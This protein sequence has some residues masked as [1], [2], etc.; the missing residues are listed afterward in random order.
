MKKLT[1]LLATSLLIAFSCQSPQQQGVASDEKDAV[2]STDKS[3]EEIDAIIATKEEFTFEAVE[4][5]I[6]DKV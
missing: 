6:K 4:M 2:E 1:L 5:M 3:K